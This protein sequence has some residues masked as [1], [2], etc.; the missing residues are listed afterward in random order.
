MIDKV[1]DTNVLF[2]TMALTISFFY[3]TQPENKI[4]EYYK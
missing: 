4:N 1:V 3:V 2:I